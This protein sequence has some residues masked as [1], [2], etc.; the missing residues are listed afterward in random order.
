MPIALKVVPPVSLPAPPAIPWAK[1]LGGLL[2]LITILM[3]TMG[4]VWGGATLMSG[5]ADKTQ[6]QKIEHRLHGLS[7]DVA[8]IKTLVQ[9]AHGRPNR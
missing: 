9:E 3:M 5:K 6:L 7:T 2:A 4:A 8:V 1:Y